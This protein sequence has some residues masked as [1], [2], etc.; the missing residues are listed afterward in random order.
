MVDLPADQS[1]DAAYGN[2][3]PSKLR[4]LHNLVIQY[5][6][7]GRYEVAIPL[8][9][10]A[11][12]DLEANLGHNHPDVA[13]MLNILALVYRLQ[14]QTVESGFLTSS[15]C[16][17]LL[18]KIVSSSVLTFHY[19]SNKME[20]GMIFEGEE[21]TWKIWLLIWYESLASHDIVA[22]E[23]RSWMCAEGNI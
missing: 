23:R 22:F 10:Q 18:L 3:V 21:V 6:G 5:A 17:R 11:L 8:C 7:Q 12:E 19:W 13:T 14:S 9:K 20:P 2:D 15:Q 4:T 16:L 1:Q